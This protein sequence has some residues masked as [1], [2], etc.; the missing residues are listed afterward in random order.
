MKYSIKRFGIYGILLALVVLAG[1]MN[2]LISTP[3][4]ISQDS[5]KGKLSLSIGTGD[6]SRTLLPK[7]AFTKYVLSFVSDGL[8]T[9]SDITL[10]GKNSAV[11]ELEPA[12]WDITATGYVMIN[13]TEYPAAA[14]TVTETISAGSAKSVSIDISAAQNAGNGYFTYSVSYPSHVSYASLQLLKLSDYS[15]VTSADLLSDPADTLAVAPGFYLMRIYLATNAEGAYRTEVVH[16]Y[17]NMETEASYTITSEDF[18][19]TIILSGT[20]DL[21]GLDV[22]YVEI[23]FYEDPNYWNWLDWVEVDLADGTWSMFFLALPVAQEMYPEIYIYTASGEDLYLKAAPV[24]V[25]NESVQN[26]NFGPFTLINLSGTV[27]LTGYDSVY[28]EVEVYAD[29]DRN[30]WLGYGEVQ[31]DGTWSVKV[32]AFTSA[33]NVYFDVYIELNGGGYADRKKADPVS[34]YNTS[35]SGIAIGP[36]ASGAITLSGTV[37]TNGL[38]LDSDS[39]DMYDDDGNYIGTAAIDTQDNSWTAN[40]TPFDVDTKVSFAVSVD[41]GSG[42]YDV[43]LSETATVRDTNVSGIALNL[44]GVT[45]GA[46]TEL[47]TNGYVVLFIPETAGAF[48]FDAKSDDIDTYMYLVDGLDG[49]VLIYDDDGGEGYNSRITYDLQAGHPYLVYSSDRW[50]SGPYTITVSQPQVITL[51]GTVNLTGI[52]ASEAWIG[53]YADSYLNNYLG[54]TQAN[55]TNGSWSITIPKSASLTAVYLELA[56]EEDSSGNWFYRYVDTPVNVSGGSVSGISVGPFNWSSIDL[57]GTVNLPDGI[58]YAYIQF[59]S[60]AGL[61]NNLAYSPV[62]SAD[63]SWS[64][65]IPAFSSS[66]VIYYEVYA[67]TNSGD[68]SRTGSLTV[69]NQNMSGITLALNWGNITLSGTVSSVLFDNEQERPFFVG[70]GADVNGKQASNSKV[71]T[72][73]SWSISLPASVSASTVS[74]YIFAGES[75]FEYLVVN[76]GVTRSVSDQD[77]GNISLGDIAVN[78]RTVNGTVKNGSSA[79]DAS[80]MALTQPITINDIMSGASSAIVPGVTATVFAPGVW[81]LVISSSA[82][83]NLY[84]FVIDW[85]TGQCYIT[86]SSVNTSSPV[87]L[88]VSAMTYLGYL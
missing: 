6:S 37:N 21:T 88:D 75:E 52:T 36:F 34:V 44:G 43:L 74:F 14:N 13:G 19:N 70:V 60:D 23:S 46:V 65:T 77:V 20:V 27:D 82:A 41:T 35:V 31:T 11:V 55:L 9:Q 87:T 68:F 86:G 54:E 8:P 69:H 30:V 81:S 49:S 78:T 80:V 1:C 76:S 38:T 84:F 72:D 29:A 39:M 22:N 28:A 71:N 66:T 42:I 79:L 63:G 7:Q 4:G 47:Y 57:D 58:N 40:I 73:G 45:L 2:P 56:V 26:I 67:D 17:S 16:I 12:T 83:Q 53:V 64:C 24:T 3:D 25:H 59:Y 50:D 61:N 33:T 18:K 62:N 85:D 51:S 5:S 48:T 10:T 32:P 15:L